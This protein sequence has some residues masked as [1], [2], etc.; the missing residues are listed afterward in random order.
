ME[1]AGGGG[2]EELEAEFAERRERKPPPPPP[3]PPLPDAEAEAGVA[4]PV[5]DIVAAVW[6][7]AAFFQGITAFSSDP[8]SY[9]WEL[10]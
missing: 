9:F 8:E 6:G 4:P 1:E 3:L 7:K 10:F 5:D 2:V